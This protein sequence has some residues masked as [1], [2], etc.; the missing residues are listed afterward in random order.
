MDVTPHT[1]SAQPCRSGLLSAR[2]QASGLQDTYEISAADLAGN[3][4]PDTDPHVSQTFQI[5]RYENSQMA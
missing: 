4:P 2:P 3:R 5:L 1:P